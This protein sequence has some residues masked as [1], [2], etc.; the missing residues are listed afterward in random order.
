M[1][2]KEIAKKINE[3]KLNKRRALYQTI[4]NELIKD[5]RF[6]LVGRGMYGLSE[7][8]LKPGIAKDVIARVLKTKG[9]LYKEEVVDL[10]KQERFLKDNTILLNLQSKKYFKRLADGR[11]HIK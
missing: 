3:L 8:G 1:H 4:H 7:F 11:Y 2:F 6:V 5:P 9:P 10:V